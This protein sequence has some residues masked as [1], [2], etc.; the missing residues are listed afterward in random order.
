MFIHPTNV[1]FLLFLVMSVHLTVSSNSW[2]M[3]WVG[4]EMN[5]MFFMPLMIIKNNKYNSESTLKYFLIQVFSS[6]IIIISSIL[7]LSSFKLMSTFVLLALLLKAGS[8]PFHQWMPSLI[9]GLNFQVILL[10]LSIQKINPMILLTTLSNTDM[11]QMIFYL[12]IF[13]S[14]FVGAISGLSQISLRKILVFSSISHMSWMLSA[15][16]MSSLTWLNY[17]LVYLMVLYTITKILKMENMTNLNQMLNKMTP[18]LSLLMPILFMSLG[19]LPPFTGFVPKLL[20]SQELLMMNELIIMA[21]LLT[22]TF[23]SLFFYSRVFFFNMLFLSK[24]KKTVKTNYTHMMAASVNL[25]GLML[26]PLSLL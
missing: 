9:E 3:V 5:M 11:S 7:T 23:I 2:F 18:N 13:S 10:L 4:L 8:A 25:L 12:A 15:I 20:I 19:G 14:G 16:M 6:N 21:V 22:S 17:F 24:T 26:I 1:F